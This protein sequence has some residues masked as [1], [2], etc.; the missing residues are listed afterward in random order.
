MLLIECILAMLINSWRPHF[1]WQK[2][3][4]CNEAHLRT[5]ISLGRSWHSW[6]SWHS[7]RS[8]SLFLLTSW[9]DSC[10][11]SGDGL[12]RPAVLCSWWGLRIFL[13]PSHTLAVD[14]LTFTSHLHA[15]IHM[16][17]FRMRWA[18]SKIEALRA[19]WTIAI[20]DVFSTNKNIW[21]SCIMQMS[22]FGAALTKYK[23]VNLRTQ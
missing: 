20:L 11:E 18:R 2:M 13:D 23:Q 9:W 21:K 12:P 6:H 19:E 15:K 5:G 3:A 22:K 7:S 10:L 4:A 1:S 14:P 17:S 8:Q 16:Q